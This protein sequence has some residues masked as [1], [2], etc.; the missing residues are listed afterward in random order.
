MDKIQEHNKDYQQIDYKG[1]IIKM[2]NRIRN[3]LVLYKI[4]SFIKAWTE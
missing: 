1:D 3:E 4:W 2:V